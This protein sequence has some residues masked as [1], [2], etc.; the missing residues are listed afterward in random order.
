VYTGHFQGT[1]KK[2]ECVPGIEGVGCA[3]S[4]PRTASKRMAVRVA[5]GI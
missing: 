2:C 1:F 3:D 4:A 5:S